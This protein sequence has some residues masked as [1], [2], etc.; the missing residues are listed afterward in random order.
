[1]DTNKTS[2]KPPPIIYWGTNYAGQAVGSTDCDARSNYDDKGP[3]IPQASPG[4]VL[5]INGNPNGNLSSIIAAAGGYVETIAFV[6]TD[7]LRNYEIQVTGC[8]PS[9]GGSLELYFLMSG[10]YVRNLSVSGSKVEMYTDSFEDSGNIVAIWW[11]LA[12]II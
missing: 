9:D 8:G 6:T 12:G 11:F 2:Q 3:I 7:G 1:M 10:G 5:N 4:T